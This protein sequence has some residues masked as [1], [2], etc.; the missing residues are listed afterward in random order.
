VPAD[1]AVVT[2]NM[3]AARG[4]LRRVVAELRGGALTSAPPAQA[5]LL[6][7][8]A[9][10]ADVRALAESAGFEILFAAARA[11]GWGNAIL[12]TLP[13]EAGRTIVLPRER[14][15]RNA[16]A[17]NVAVAGHTLFVV[18]A[19]LENRVSW[20]RG[21]LPSDTARGRQAAALLRELP[22]DAPG[23]LGG[24]LNTWLGAGEPAW[25]LFAARFPDTPAAVTP[26]FR[27]RLVLDHLFFDLPQGWRADTRVL[28][29]RYGSNHHPVL[30]LV[31][32]ASGR[33]APRRCRERSRRARTGRRSPGPRLR[34]PRSRRRRC[35]ATS[36]P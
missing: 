2:W 33:A 5:V 18:S 13:L 32:S 28:D 6:L 1:L 22:A 24:D 14:Q 27:E 15:R 16:V 8:E 4:D 34:A 25:R 21:G 20:W 11:P 30:G 29:E 26:T 31:F 23:I 19:H 35:C 3:D 7:Q 12:A 17:A 9:R 10:E 36:A